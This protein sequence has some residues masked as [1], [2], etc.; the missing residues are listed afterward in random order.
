M[1]IFDG[2]GTATEAPVQNRFESLHHRGA[3]LAGAHDI[4]MG[5]P[6][7]VIRR[8]IHYQRLAVANNRSLHRGH[9]VNRCYSSGKDARCIVPQL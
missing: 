4:D 2:N 6:P 8:T 5:I 7:Q 1:A 9:R 3:G